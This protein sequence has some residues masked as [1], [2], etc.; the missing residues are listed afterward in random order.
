MKK[1]ELLAP[2]GSMDAL[3]AAIMAGCDAVYLSG[4]KYG[5]RSFASNFSSDE[6]IEAIRYAHL[7]GVKVYVTVNTLIYENE[8]DDFIDY[9]DFLHRNSVDAII[10]Q[11]IGMMDLIR[12][13]YPNLEIHVSTQMHVH[14]LEGVKFFKGLGLKRV[15]L[16]R[17][18]PIELIDKIKKETSVEVEVFV[19]GALC[20]S[21]S[22]Q[23]LM[24]SLIGGRSGNRG[25]CAGC[26][27]LPYDLVVDGKKVNK[28]KYLLSTKDLMTLDHIGE[29]IDCGIDSFKIEGR[30]KRANYVYLVVS[31]YRK[32]IDSYLN[33]GKVLID[34]KDITD[35]KKMFNREFTK[36]Y[37]FSEKYIVNQKRPNH[38]GVF[39]GNVVDYRNGYAYVKLISSVNV[40]DGIRIISDNDVG[41]TL[42]S[43]FI[44]DKLVTSGKKGDIIYFKTDFVLNGSKVVKTTD[45]ILMKNIDD[46][47]S[48]KK[49]KVLI[50][51]CI[52]LYKNKNVCLRLYDGVNNICVYGDLVS[53]AVNKPLSKGDVIKQ[54]DRLGDTVFSFKSLDVNMD[55]DIFVPISKLNALRR[56]AISMLED[57]RLY[58]TNYRK[59]GYSCDVFNFPSVSKYSCL[60]SDAS[61]DV[62]NFD[63]VYTDNYD[64]FKNSNDVFY[65]VPRVNYRYKDVSSHVL[66][67]EFGSLYKYNCVDTDF[68]F[69]VVNSYSVA[70][71]HSIG[72]NKITLSYELNVDQIENIVNAYKK[73]YSKHPNLEVI[74]SSYPEVMVSKFNIFDYY[75]VKNGY[76]RDKYGNL[77]SIK[78]IDGLMY[79]Y[80]Y[81]KICL[82]ACNLFKIGINVVRINF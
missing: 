57:K 2:A 78:I 18:T 17:E 12:K 28:N 42:N 32:V 65:K 49:R 11:D 15:V 45:S 77:Y 39:I 75:G 60:V 24:S 70:F 74:I 40:F 71:L 20:I 67:G 29:L 52:E 6:I 4:K 14:N 22:G 72:V 62:S 53:Q 59:C 38:M 44:K 19:H 7:Y 51:G 31:L 80:N 43:F 36:G 25:A 76:L 66:V 81:K 68:S 27:R 64:L 46:M 1:P 9:I 10:I 23:C 30:M 61:L 3:V 16:A 47:I 79:I 35:M 58:K 34:D 56:D 73:R 48:T 55:N 82:D 5:A 69:N 63:Y 21:Y 41:L 26:C 37:L 33:S 50:D 13:M 8:V 54:M